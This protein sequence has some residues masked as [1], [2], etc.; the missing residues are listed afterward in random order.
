MIAK[1]I[2]YYLLFAFVGA[3]ITA[4]IGRLYIDYRTPDVFEAI[5]EESKS[6]KVLMNS[7]GGYK[8]LSTIL[9][10]MNSRGI[11]LTLKL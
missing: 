11:A 1:K 6:N 8:S 4:Q 5:H 2:M 9:M 7:I 3:F 10:R